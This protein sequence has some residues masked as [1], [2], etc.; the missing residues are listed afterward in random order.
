MKVVEDA[1]HE[2]LEDEVTEKF[3]GGETSSFHVTQSLRL[4]RFLVQFSFESLLDVIPDDQQFLQF[5][6]EIVGEQVG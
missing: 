3:H 4:A 5:G 6:V 1:D 2:V